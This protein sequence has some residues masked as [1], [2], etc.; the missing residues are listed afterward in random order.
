MVV[1]GARVF[2]LLAV[3]T[4]CRRCAD[5]VQ[6]RLGVL[7]GGPVKI[8]VYPGDGYGSGNLRLRLPARQVGATVS[9][10][11]LAGVW[12]DVGGIRR[13]VRVDTDADV[14]V[15]H[16]PLTVK[17]IE[18]LSTLQ[19]QGVA[20]VVDIDDDPLATH[21]DNQGYIASHPHWFA[22]DE[23]QVFA[24]ISGMDMERRRT[25]VASDG[26]CYWWV[27]EAVSNSRGENLL[28]V[29]RMA[30]MVTVTTPALAER[31][32]PHGRVRVLRNAVPESWLGIGTDGDSISWTGHLGTHVND[33]DVLGDSIARVTAETGTRFRCVDN[34]EAGRVLGVKA[35]VAKWVSFERY[36]KV[37]AK[38][39]RLGIVPL[40][41][42]DF[43]AA[44]SWLKGMELAAWGIPFVATPTPSYVELHDLGAGE[45]AD[46]PEDWY[47]TMSELITNEERR[48]D[49]VGKGLE[50]ARNWTIEGRAEHWLEAWETALTTRNAQ[51]AKG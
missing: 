18:T 24:E 33:L 12:Q 35:K 32:A 43:N 27:P 21:P 50:V 47:R 8:V 40:T 13:C 34:D 46:S 3:P 31:Y 22:E 16:R 20:V 2:C 7:I 26:T 5:A 28:R 10:E 15:V 42:N 17:W 11:D 41:H 30:D 14:V 49:V 29:A 19:R 23:A 25:T 9:E 1:R 45:L 51:G 37:H 44:K 6:Y 39:V 4:L 38:G 48:A 36:P